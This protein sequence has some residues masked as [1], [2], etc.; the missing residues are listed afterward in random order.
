MVGMFMTVLDTTIVNVAVPTMQQDF[1]AT[2]DDIQWVTT[3]YTLCL[4][5]VVPASAWL[6]ARFGLTRIYLIS[7]V[8]FSGA[9]ALC[10]FAWDLNSMIAFRILQAVPGGII[11]AICLTAVYRIVPRPRIGTAMG[12]YGFGLVVAPA[13]G[14][15]LGGYLVEYTHWRLVFYMNVPLG[16]LGALAALAVLPSVP[17][18]RGRPFDLPGFGAIAGGLFMLLLAV[19]EGQDWGWSSY[20]VLILVVG[21]LLCLAL[22]VVIELEVD[23]PLL[24]VRIF[25]HRAFTNSMILMG[26]N[27]VGL[28]AMLFYLPLFLQEGQKLTAFHTGLVVLPQAMVTMTMMPIA[29]RIFDRIGARWPAVIGLAVNGAGTLLMSGINPD[30]TRADVIGATMLRSVGLG[31]S[32]MPI[33]TG[34]LAALPPPSIASGSAFNNVV[35]RVA[36]ALGLAALTAMATATQAQV[37]AD[38]ATLMPSG[39]A[40]VDAQLATMQGQ[41]SPGLYPLMQ[42]LQVDT[43][44]QSYGNVFQVVGVM[45]LAGAV[46]ALFLPHGAPIRRP[47]PGGPPAAGRP[48]G[49]GGRP[50]EPAGPGGATGASTG[51]PRVVAGPR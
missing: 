24:D 35:Q 4:G 14:P 7:L 1:G 38:R 47:G 34:G 6:G 21:G 26:I 33:M 44:A 50:G 3:A 19:S 28:F 13:V 5:V 31:L 48:G 49:P 29:G 27:A 15:T 8:G 25:R 17:S 51:R 37:M 11:P 45:T 22:F 36:S 40:S 43:M 18:A 12:L 32:M 20:P 16:I 23:A 2:T 41:G 10:G 39:G 30:M 9:S 42:Q 46:L